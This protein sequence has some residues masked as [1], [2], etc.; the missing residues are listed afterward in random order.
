MSYSYIIDSSAWIEYFG[1][2]VKGLK[3]KALIEQEEIATSIVAL[4]EV[5]DKFERENRRFEICRI[6]MQRRAAVL[7]LTVEIAL[8]AAKLKKKQREKR[9]KFSI[10][11]GIRL[12][13]ALQEGAV[14]VTADSD[15]AGLENA[16][17][18]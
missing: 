13:T 10:A 18:V 5:A 2:T 12:A 16:M 7:P 11:D 4:L 3:I 9:D 6:F 1:A 14:L 15:F 8:A 17:V